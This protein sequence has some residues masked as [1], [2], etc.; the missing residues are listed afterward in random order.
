MTT[1]PRPRL[2]LHTV[3]DDHD[4]LGAFGRHARAGQTQGGELAAVPPGLTDAERYAL[5][6]VA[7]P[8]AGKRAPRGGLALATLSRPMRAAVER[9]A[10]AGRVTIRAGAATLPPAPSR[11]PLVF[12]AVRL[13]ASLVRRLDRAVAARRA[14]APED[15][16]TRSHV[17]RVA[18]ARGLDGIGGDR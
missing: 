2:A 18:L 15:R 7:D 16:P 1:T 11:D 14:A 3:I 13:P 4:P 8:P 17:M 10:A 12:V 6:L 5:S 9:L